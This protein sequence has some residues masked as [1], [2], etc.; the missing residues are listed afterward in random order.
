MTEE[1]ILIAVERIDGAL[2]RMEAAARARADA[3]QPAD[4][5]E[6]VRLRERHAAMRG[7]VEEALGELDMLIRNG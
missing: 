2:S 3:P 7:R 6:L 5:A 1:R 4:N